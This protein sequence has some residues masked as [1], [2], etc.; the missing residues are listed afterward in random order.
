M[1]SQGPS[2][3]HDGLPIRAFPVD[4]LLNLIA[5][6]MHTKVVKF[7]LS[8]CNESRDIFLELHICEI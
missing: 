3:P 6:T 5:I 7:N 2:S 4:I 8:I 1:Q